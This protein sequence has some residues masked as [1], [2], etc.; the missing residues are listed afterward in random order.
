[1]Q[2][3]IGCLD[4]LRLGE[5]AADGTCPRGAA[6]ARHCYVGDPVFLGRGIRRRELS[7]RWHLAVPVELQPCHVRTWVHH[8][9]S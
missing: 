8:N 6:M 1:M 3:V 7:H 9:S 5:R 4:D 2:Q